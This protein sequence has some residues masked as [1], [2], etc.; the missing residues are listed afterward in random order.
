[1]I[2]SLIGTIGSIAWLAP[3]ANL[4]AV[5]VISIVVV[6]LDL[7]AGAI[8]AL[9]KEG[10]T[11]LIH[12]VDSIVGLVIAYLRAA[13]CLR[14]ERVAR[15]AQ[16]GQPCILSTA[17]CALMMLP[18][19]MRH[20]A[21]LLPCVLLPVLPFH[22]PPNDGEFRVTVLDVGQGLSVVVETAR[23]RLLYDAG[24]RF[25]SG[26]DLGRAV[27]V[28]NLRRTAA[29]RT[30]CNHSQSRRSGS[31][32]RLRRQSHKRFA[33]R[34][35]LGG[36][37]VDGLDALRPC[38]AGQGWQWDGV[39]FR[40]LHPSRDVGDG[41]RSVVR[42]VDCQRS[43]ECVVARRHHPRWRSRVARSCIAIRS[44]FLSRRITVAVRR[45]AIPSCDIRAPAHRRVQRRLYE[46]LRSST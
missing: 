28:P 21:L 7:I 43:C 18:L 30:R 33:V 38:R 5:P 24:P 19:T 15:R 22:A 9:S 16:C 40:V 17:A 35:L 42:A 39:R 37:S 1:M 3:A 41:Q 32:R 23:H 20:R 13:G 29:D 12:F 8:V 2:P 11:W 14:L 27:V 25:P 6:P 4:I 31:R 44:T 34:A 26:L 36:E 46:P 45:R 10:D